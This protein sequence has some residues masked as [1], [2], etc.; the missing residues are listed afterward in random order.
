MVMVRVS[1]VSKGSRLISAQSPASTG[2]AL[3]SSIF[4]SVSSSLYWHSRPYVF[5]ISPTVAV[6]A[7]RPTQTRAVLLNVTLSTLA[8]N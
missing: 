2:C 3:I 5:L 8:R 7:I 4:A 6:S 1:S